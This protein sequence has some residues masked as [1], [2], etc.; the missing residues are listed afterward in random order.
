MQ[1]TCEK[2]GIADFHMHDIRA[3]MTTFLT[4]VGVDESVLRHVMHHTD[5]TNKHYNR[6]VGADRLRNA[7][8]LWGDYV[9]SAV[10]KNGVTATLVSVAARRRLQRDLPPF[11][12]VAQPAAWQGSAAKRP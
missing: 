6:A 3:A 5:V 8:Q 11:L 7:W 9:E 2:A 4:E 12:L 10:S 1:R